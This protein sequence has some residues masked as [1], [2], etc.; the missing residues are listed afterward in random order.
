MAGNDTI[1][2]TE[3]YAVGGGVGGVVIILLSVI[4]G[5]VAFCRCKKMKARK[6]TKPGTDPH[7]IN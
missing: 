1:P 5:S 2:S 6:R 3:L 4:A 7:H